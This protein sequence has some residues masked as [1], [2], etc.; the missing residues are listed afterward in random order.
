MYYTNCCRSRLSSTFCNYEREAALKGTGVPVIADGGIRYSGDMAKAIV[1]GAS[2][3]M[4]GSMLAGTR[5]S[6]GE[7]VIFEGRKYKTYRGMGSLEAMK[8]GSKD[9]YFQDVENDDKKLVPEG[10]VGKS[11]F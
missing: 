9:R 5:E 8:K 3:V 2:S 11:S 6:P 4:M 1:A 7:T 10:I